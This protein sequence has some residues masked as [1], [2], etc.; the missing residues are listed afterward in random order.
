MEPNNETEAEKDFENAATLNQQRRRYRRKPK[1]VLDLVNDVISR[2][3]IA[4]EKSNNQLQNLW[5]QV[6]GIDIAN[7]TKAGALRRGIL[8]VIVS[9]SSLM[10][11]LG[12][13]KPD[14][15][16]KLNQEIKHGTI[17]DIRFRI[18][19]IC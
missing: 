5:D 4:A 8:E 19:R 15:L 16:E 12:F 14:F 1:R 11:E 13:S 3:G 2:R 10:Q 17:K 7:Q 6:V 18:G 9:N